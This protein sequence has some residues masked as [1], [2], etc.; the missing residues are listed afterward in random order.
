MLF[1]K[2]VLGKLLFQNYLPDEIYQSVSILHFL[3]LLAFQSKFNMTRVLKQ[4]GVTSV[5]YRINAKYDFYDYVY[6]F[7]FL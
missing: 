4:H 6:I 2:L 5:R 7:Q 1:Q 3:F